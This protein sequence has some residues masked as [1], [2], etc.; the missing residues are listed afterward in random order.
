[1]EIIFKHT[2]IMFI[3]VT[4]A[5]GFILKYRSKKYIAQNPEL[6]EGYR[7]YFKG[8]MF[9]GN[10]PWVIM[11]LGNLS[12]ITQNTFEYFNPKA[13]NPMVLVFHFSIIVLWVLGIRWIYFKSGAEFIEAH[14]GL[15]QKSN[16]SGN[17]NVTAK[18]IKIFVPLM[19]FGGIAGMVLMWV[20]DI[21]DLPF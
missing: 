8:W 1:M 5:N 20:M 4:V 3:A 16:F 15:I 18:Q 19:I 21:P 2:W 7:N 6:D 13:M 9:Y 14:P 10:L 12:G 17:S 11:M